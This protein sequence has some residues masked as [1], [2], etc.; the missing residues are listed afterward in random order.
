MKIR[1]CSKCRAYTLKEEHCGKRTISP[2][3]P[4]FSPE[5]EKKYGKYRRKAKALN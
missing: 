1:K 5:K 2:H 4:K 3:P